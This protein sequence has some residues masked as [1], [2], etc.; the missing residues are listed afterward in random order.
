MAAFPAVID[1]SFASS[2]HPMLASLC[3]DSGEID[4]GESVAVTRAVSVGW[5]TPCPAA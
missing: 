3:N 4:P 1:W 5:R 2:T